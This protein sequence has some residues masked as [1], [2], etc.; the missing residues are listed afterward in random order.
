MTTKH[1]TSFLGVNLKKLVPKNQK[2][3]ESVIRPR[4]AATLIIVRRDVVPPR[5]LMGQRHDNHVF[6]PNKYVF[7]GGGVDPGD[8]RVKPLT[9][10]SSQVK[11]GLLQGCSEARAR[12]LA[13]AAI[14]ETFEE[15][16]LIVGEPHDNQCQTR[17]KSWLPFFNQGF[18]PTLK[19]LELIARAI[20]PPNRIRRFDARFFCVDAQYVH[21]LEHPYMTGSGELLELCWV[22]LTE[23]QNLDTSQITRI[24][25][26]VLEKRLQTSLDEVEKIK[27]PF[28]Y[29]RYGRHIVDTIP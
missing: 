7:P 6:L 1:F 9:D 23:G 24:I 12:G 22:T 16:G 20:T 19:P 27:I 5:V 21:G 8:S 3:N 28:Y 29:S 25:L 11:K 26:K 15:A 18:A 10:L 4:D 14:R 17:S 13:M 2:N